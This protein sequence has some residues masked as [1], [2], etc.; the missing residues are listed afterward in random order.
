MSEPLKNISH[1]L[2][3]TIS[4]AEFLKTAA[5]TVAV[6]AVPTSLLAQD[7]AGKRRPAGSSDANAANVTGHGLIRVWNRPVDP[8]R[9]PGAKA[10]P[11]PAVTWG[12]LGGDNICQ[13]IGLRRFQ[14]QRDVS[15]VQRIVNY[16]ETLDL[17]TK[18]YDFGR[19]IAPNWQM[20][21][22]ENYREVI[23]EI[24]ARGL[25]LHHV[26]GYLPKEARGANGPSG[27]PAEVNEY[28]ST[29][30]G[31]HFTGFDNG[32][33]DCRFTLK[34]VDSYPFPNNRRE[35]YE[36]FMDYEWAIAEDLQ[37][38]FSAL[39]NNTFQP[40]LADIGDT[41]MIG[42]QIAQSKPS[43]PMWFS[44][45]R[46][47]GKQY[48][49]LYWVSPSVWNR[50]GG[51][52]FGRGAEGVI[53]GTSM[54]LLY[55]LWN[56]A[57]MYGVAVIMSEAAN[58]DQEKKVTLKV[59][60][61]DREVP[62]P[63]P[64]GRQHLEMTKWIRNH[65]GRGVL[66]TPV[67]IVWDFYTGWVPPRRTPAD[68]R[69]FHTWGVMP[70]E[71]GDYQI[72][73]LFREL[74]PGYEDASYYRDERGFLTPTPWGDGYDVGMSNVPRFVLSRYS[75][76]VIIGP[77]RIEGQ[78]QSTV[79]DFIA[80]GGSVATTAA[81]LTTE[82]A[83]AFGVRLTGKTVTERY[84]QIASGV[85]F[86][87]PI[88]TRHE[89][90]PL[91]GTEVLA[92]SYLG[93]PLVLR[94]KTREGGELL[95]FAADFGLSDKV[96]E[97][98]AKA[99]ENVPIPASYLMLSHV[100]AILLPWMAQWNLVEVEGPP[101]QFL[102]NLTDDPHRVI[103]TLSNNSAF[104]WQG[105]VRLKGARIASGSNWMRDR[106]IAAGDSLKL[107]IASEDIVVVELRADRP[108]V[109]FRT[110][111]GPTPTP[112]ELGHKSGALFARWAELAG[113]PKLAEGYRL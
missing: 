36:H 45:L 47:A 7:Q 33:H 13:T 9:H 82:T 15:G 104:P 72:D 73:A 30:L 68:N 101:V 5:G 108:L 14:I 74:Y 41:R 63:D 60:G 18:V 52:S 64:L 2:K 69:P 1:R 3:S 96:A 16:K 57:Y 113:K 24:K 49:L 67:A 109:A 29:T 26:W 37:H 23:D 94:R 11:Q 70:Y 105:A 87:E 32:E 34:A 93:R 76:G 20:I 97:P 99:E 61:L 71:K 98:P 81:Q 19:A 27:V 51:K 65:P 85:A 42:C 86:N 44:L 31:R 35:G 112:E 12:D 92:T 75:A 84:A 62:A 79:E 4:R 46:G 56:L 66:H 50:W 95:V 106:A 77:T 110:D 8:S 80:R 100:K 10:R 53:N 103:V 25:L 88:Y 83:G 78:L 102:T 17:Y 58:M 43:V 28:I 59:D 89:L 48:G 91:D 55:R 21:F 90:E 54:S 39:G 38:N 6:A 22:C 107:E 40:Y 111:E